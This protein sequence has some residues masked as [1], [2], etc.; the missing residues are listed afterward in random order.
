LACIK[1]NT[2]AAWRYCYG[3]VTGA[4]VTLALFLVEP[5]SSSELDQAEVTVTVDGSGR[6]II[7]AILVI[8]AICVV[9]PVLPFRK[10]S[11]SRRLTLSRTDRVAGVHRATVEAPDSLGA[12]ILTSVD[13]SSS[14][15]GRDDAQALTGIQ[16]WSADDR[17]S[18]VTPG[19]P[20]HRPPFRAR[21]RYW[22]WRFIMI[23]AV[24]AWFA[25][26]PNGARTID[27]RT[28][29]AYP[30]GGRYAFASRSPRMAWRWTAWDGLALLAVGCLVLVAITHSLGGAKKPGAVSST[31]S[32]TLSASNRG[33]SLMNNRLTARDTVPLEIAAT[34]FE[35]P[36]ASNGMVPAGQEVVAFH[37]RLTNVL[38]K[39][40]SFDL[41]GF[42]L[43][44]LRS[45]AVYAPQFYVPL[46]DTLLIN[47]SL[48]PGT[49]TTGDLAFYVAAGDSQ[50]DLRYGEGRRK[51]LTMP[52][53]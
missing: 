50:F 53:R 12:A 29:A 6:L 46:L 20:S 39:P 4:F 14:L 23:V 19:R 1:Q 8:C 48:D 32:T 25:P 38:R 47:A 49:A 35:P 33:T 7:A 51:V 3:N 30:S 26:V 9:A 27:D 40:E 45:G 52:V 21:P 24:E 13:A 37:V 36:A 42:T 43:H 2:G 17:G 5:A 31:L 22:W 15:D 16:A 10:R 41:G 28:G 11:K 18:A 44:S 34:R